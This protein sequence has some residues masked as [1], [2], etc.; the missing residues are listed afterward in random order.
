MSN[1]NMA[2]M[3]SAIVFEMGRG[4][5]RQFRVVP[6][7][8]GI[9]HQVNLEYVAQTVWTAEEKYAARGKPS[10]VEVAYPIRSFG[11]DSHTTMVNGLSV[12]GWASAASRPKRACSVSRFP[13]CCRR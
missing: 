2:A 3:A 6:P 1:S 4:R 12:S 8:T 5:V 9:C 13:C 11:T 7:G 10:N